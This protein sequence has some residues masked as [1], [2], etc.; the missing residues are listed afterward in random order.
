MSVKPGGS[1]SEPGRNCGALNGRG[2]NPLV[3]G[4]VARATDAR[5]P[6]PTPNFVGNVIHTAALPGLSPGPVA[7]DGRPTPVLVKSSR[8]SYV[9]PPS[10][11]ISTLMV[12][13]LSVT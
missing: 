10:A 8:K 13:W 12:V 11:L 4:P 5:M 9:L 2:S 1:E 7:S 3:P 6:S